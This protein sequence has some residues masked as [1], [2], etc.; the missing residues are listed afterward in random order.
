MLLVNKNKK[1]L[2]IKKF[3]VSVTDKFRALGLVY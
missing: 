2:L 3:T 1:F